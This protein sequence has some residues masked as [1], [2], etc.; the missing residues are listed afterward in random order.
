M[1]NPIRIRPATPADRAAVTQLFRRSYP[2]LLPA[3]YDPR[4]L[5]EA[6]PHITTAQPSLLDCGT[7]FVA[8]NPQGDI[9]GAGGWTDTSPAR[10]VAGSGEGHVRHVATHP[11]HLRQGLARQMIEAT[12]ASARA[13]GVDR[14]NC[15]STLAARSFYRSMGFSEVGEVELTLAQG[16]HFPAVQ[17][18]CCL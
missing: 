1:S 8:Q 5:R 17:M 4:V 3:F 15:M 18:V 2:Q 12:F 9:V 16:V 6:L 14:M 7:Y 13:F 10:G 11:A